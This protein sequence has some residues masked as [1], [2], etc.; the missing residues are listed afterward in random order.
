MFRDEPGTLLAPTPFLASGDEALGSV[1][2]ADPGP[3]RGRHWPT[4]R[5][6]I[7]I[8]GA[9]LAVMV[10]ALLATDDRQPKSATPAVTSPM[11]TTPSLPASLDQAITDLQRAVQP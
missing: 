9:V 8:T 10:G 3:D 1:G 5:R 11:T 6:A 7:V 4:V 2:P